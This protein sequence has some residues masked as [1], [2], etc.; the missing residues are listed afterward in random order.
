LTLRRSRRTGHSAARLSLFASSLLLMVSLAATSFAAA[1]P[2]AAATPTTAPAASSSHGSLAGADNSPPVGV[3]STIA[4]TWQGGGGASMAQQPTGLA[5]EAAG[6]L[7]AN[8]GGNFV[9]LLAARSATET[10]LAGDGV[11]GENGDNRLA[12]TA[13]LDEPTAVAVDRRGD[14]IIADAYFNRIRLVAAAS[15]SSGCPYNLRSMVKGNIYTMAGDGTPGYSGNDGPAVDAAIDAPSGIAI[16]PLGDLLIADTYNSAIRLVAWASCSSNCPYDLHSMV[17]GDIYTIAGTGSYGDSGAGG[18]AV[19]AQLALPTGIAVDRSGD[20]IITDAVNNTVSLVAHSN[21]PSSCDF[22]LGP[23]TAGYIY[24]LAGTGFPGYSGVPAPA[25]SAELDGPSGV[26]V[27]KGGNVL[28]ADTEND[29]VE[30]VAASSCSSHCPY[31]LVSTDEGDLY[32]VVGDNVMGYSG[33]DGPGLEAELNAPVGLAV[34]PAGNLLIADS[35]NNRVRMLAA[36]NCTSSCAYGRS[37]TALDVYTVAGDGQ[38]SASGEGTAARSAELNSPG[39]VAVDTRRDVVIAD[40]QNNLIRLVAA[41]SC[42]SSC[43]YGLHSTVTGAIYTVAGNGTAGYSGD[44]GLAVDAELADPGGVGIG[45]SGD[46]VFADTGNNRIRLLAAVNCSSSCPYGLPSTRV[47]DIYTVAGTG[48]GGYSGDS[49]RAASAKLSEPGDVTAGPSG[50]L[51]VADSANSRIRLVADSNCARSCPYGLPSTI[52]GDIY[53]LAGDGTFG[54]S[55]DGGAARSSGARLARPGGVAIGP[56]SDLIV[57]DTM[58]NAIRLVAAVTCRS[59]CPY[60]LPS[61]TVGDIYTVAGNGKFGYSGDGAGR[62]ASLAAPTGVTADPAGDIFVADSYN[63]AVRVISNE[64]CGNSCPYGV[65]YASLGFIS[66]VAGTGAFGGSPDAAPSTSLPLADPVA[67]A[68]YPGGGVVIVEAGQDAVRLLTSTPTDG[69]VVAT[70]AGA[71]FN[72]GSPYY[73]SAANAKLPAPI[74]AIS[75]DSLGGYWLA[76]TDGSIYNFG[77]AL[78]YGSMRGHHLNKPV[79]GMAATVQGN[80]YWMVATDGGMFSFGGAHFYGSMGGH[81]L[82]KPIVAMAAAPGGEGYWLVASD[83]GIFTFGDAHF[84]GSMG[85]SHLNDPIVGMAAAPGGHGYWLVASDGGI[86]TFGDARFLGSGGSRRLATPVA[87]MQADPGTGGYRLVEQNGGVLS[88]DA[89]AYGSSLNPLPGRAVSM[90][91]N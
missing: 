1:P 82:N 4:G 3:L 7:I 10:V 19:Q 84:Y 35:G 62:T 33:D 30:M 12:T 15:C 40:S 23:E 78:S 48:I 75:D 85:G 68:A 49:G 60:G 11:A 36:A 73:G 42:S 63:D 44:G 87:A 37:T 79:V 54:Y 16:D 90:A 26:S 5:V 77:S 28:V 2:A 53:T 14:T 86:F 64:D 47:G 41:A 55:G 69:F 9:Q 43:P 6:V 21:C 81:H 66:T 32:T 8:Q 80:G 56:S 17:A 38:V 24:T 72:Y 29:V 91:T 31:G 83:G 22:G 50:D 27:D 76:G 65:G 20:A 57:S 25:A 46:I 59:S 88:F 74:T 52:V 45:A 61:T 58:N 71:V 18:P 89:R 13:A 51:L 34:D 39:G 67:V 70:A